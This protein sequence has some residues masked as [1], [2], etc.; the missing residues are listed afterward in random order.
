MLYCLSA[1]GEGVNVDYVWFANTRYVICKL[2]NFLV[3][4]ISDYLTV[5]GRQ[6]NCCGDSFLPLHH[7]VVKHIYDY[8]IVCRQVL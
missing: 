4:V 8:S 2:N 7:G 1:T 3:V 5:N 6:I